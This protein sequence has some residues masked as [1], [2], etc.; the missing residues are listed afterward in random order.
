MRG[1]LQP[2]LGC[3]PGKNMSKGMAAS[4]VQSRFCPVQLQLRLSMGRSVGS[5]RRA[6]EGGVSMPC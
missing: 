4:E 3:R 1:N 2:G 5:E 6:V